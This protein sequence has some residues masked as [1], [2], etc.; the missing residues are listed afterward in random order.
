MK[1][2]WRKTFFR[3]DGVNPLTAP[4]GL[5][6]ITDADLTPGSHSWWQCRYCGQGES[7][8]PFTIK[9]EKARCTAHEDACHYRRRPLIPFTR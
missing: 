3:Y 2:R 9:A 5:P 6:P 7:G 4:R 8:I 1:I